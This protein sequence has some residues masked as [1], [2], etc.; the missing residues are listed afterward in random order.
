MVGE[1]DYMKSDYSDTGV[2]Q[3]ALINRKLSAK[4]R[5]QRVFIS[6]FQLLAILSVFFIREGKKGWHKLPIP[7]NDHLNIQSDHFCLAH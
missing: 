5:R 3:I 4:G 6:F 2:L 1:F 7:L